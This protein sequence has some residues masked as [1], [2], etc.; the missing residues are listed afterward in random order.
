MVLFTNAE[1]HC[2]V[3][4]LCRT[5]ERLLSLNLQVINIFILI[6]Q[7]S[8]LLLFLMAIR[9]IIFITILPMVI[10]FNI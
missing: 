7:K 4:E 9:S 1:G 3:S 10:L 8:S 6:Q 2:R 5:L